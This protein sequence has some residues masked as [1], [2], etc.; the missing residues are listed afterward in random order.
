VST[1]E[2][3]SAIEH[4]GAIVALSDAV[5]ELA[6]IMAVQGSDLSRS[7]PIGIFRC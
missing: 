3:P 6:A 5:M 7:R 4:R 1:L 2:K